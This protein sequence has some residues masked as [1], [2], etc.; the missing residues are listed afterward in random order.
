[1]PAMPPANLAGPSKPK[2]ESIAASAPTPAKTTAKETRV[3]EKP[4]KSEKPKAAA[5]KMQ[6]FFGKP[7]E[8]AKPVEK[9]EPQ[10][11]K[12]QEKRAPKEESKKTREMAKEPPHVA[13]T[14]KTTLKSNQVQRLSWPYEYIS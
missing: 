1:M 5:D 13:S 12:E 14:S 9:T 8:K 6:S 3:A 11:N 7:K 4:A 2:A 10:K